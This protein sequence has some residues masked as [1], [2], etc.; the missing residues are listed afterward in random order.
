[1]WRRD[2]Y[3]GKDITVVALDL[4]VTGLNRNR[5][6]I[7]Q[8]G[9]YGSAANGQCIECTAVVDAEVPTGRDPANL[10]G[11]NAEDLD[12]AVPLR[13][14][15]LKILYEYLHDAIVVCHNKHHDW[16]I[17]HAEFQRNNAKVPHPRLVCCTLDLCRFRLNIPPPHTLG[18]LCQYFCIPLTLAHNALHDARATF[19]LFMILVNEYW[20][21]WFCY[22]RLFRPLW[23]FRSHHWPPK[24]AGRIPIY[25]R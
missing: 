8:Y 3:W 9:L 12:N 1:M 7:L 4:E 23:T 14:G 18:A 22:Q 13:Q 20:D 10:L 15:H 25:F 19:W 5:D 11:I 24:Q 16:S 2:F 17:I 21:S 6:R